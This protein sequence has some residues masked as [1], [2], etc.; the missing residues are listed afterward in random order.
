MQPYPILH[1]PLQYHKSSCIELNKHVHK[2]TSPAVKAF[3]SSLK[4]LNIKGGCQSCFSVLTQTTTRCAL[5]PIELPVSLSLSI[6]G[7]DEC[8]LTEE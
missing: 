3:F 2:K 1:Y 6:S 7:G 5:R 8:P 4:N